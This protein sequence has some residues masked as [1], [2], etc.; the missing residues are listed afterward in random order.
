[1]DVESLTKLITLVG[2]V[3]AACTGVWSLWL[4]M[5]GKRDR[6]AVR[7]GTV[8]PEIIRETMMHVVSHSDHP[9]QLADYGFIDPDFKF[10]SIPLERELSDFHDSHLYQRGESVLEKRS[11]YFEIGYIRRDTPIG[12]FAKSVTQSRPTIGFAWDTPVWKKLW[13]RT[14]LLVKGRGYLR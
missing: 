8:R 6:F 1:M 14:L 4:Q 10:S 9:I 11:D 7:P 2:A 3:I 13:V 5:R 12:A